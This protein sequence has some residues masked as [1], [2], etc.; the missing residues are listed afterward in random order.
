MCTFNINPTKL[1][2]IGAGAQQDR[3]SLRIRSVRGEAPLFGLPGN[4]IT[5]PPVGAK[6]EHK[7]ERR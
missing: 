7:A 3:H 1:L 2:L 6:P 4:S 5:H